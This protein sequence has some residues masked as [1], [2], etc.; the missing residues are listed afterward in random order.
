VAAGP[1]VSAPAAGQAHQARLAA[2][3]DEDAVELQVEVGDAG[4]VRKSQSAQDGGEPPRDV[5]V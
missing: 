4:L 1:A 5:V 2:F 3:V